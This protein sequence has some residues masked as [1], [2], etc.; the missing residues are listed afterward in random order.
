MDTEVLA[1]HCNYLTI[2]EVR[3]LRS[4]VKKLGPKDQVAVNIGA[5]AG[6]SALALLEGHSQLRVVSVDYDPLRL[7]DERTAVYDAGFNGRL[8]QICNDSADEGLSWTL[9]VDFVF[10][11]GDHS[12]DHVKADVQAWLPHIREGGILCGHDYGWDK[13]AGVKQAFDEEMVEYKRIALV[14]HLIGYFV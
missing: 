12:Y 2:M 7:R 1:V 5:G 13:W 10:I 8:A 11:D 6:T 14:D 9:P 4:W 3:A